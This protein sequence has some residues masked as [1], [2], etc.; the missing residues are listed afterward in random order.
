MLGRDQAGE[1]GRPGG[2]ADRVAAQCPREADTFGGHPVDVWGA[3]V[4]IAVAAEGPRAL[5]VGQDE[6]EVYRLGGSGGDQG[7]AEE[8]K[9]RT[10][11]VQTA[12]GRGIWPLF[13]G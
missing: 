7:E 1:K 12:R 4:G 2:G 6:D 11:G 8:G 3:D 5:V 10:H 13:L 9:E